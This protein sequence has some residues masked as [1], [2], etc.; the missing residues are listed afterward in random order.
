MIRGRF[1]V[2]RRGDFFDGE[3]CVFIGMNL[4]VGH[5]A[6]LSAFAFF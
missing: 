3:A 6:K 5:P 4:E 2:L 1:G